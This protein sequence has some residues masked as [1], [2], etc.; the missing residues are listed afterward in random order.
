MAIEFQTLDTTGQV[1]PERQRLLQKL[2]LAVDPADAVSKK[3]FGMNWKMT[4]KTI[5]VQLHHKVETLEHI[6]KHFALVIQ[7]YLIDYLKQQFNFAHLNTGL[8]G[9]SFHIHVYRLA[10]KSGQFQ[11]SLRQRLSTDAAGVAASLSLQSSA[12][13]EL[14]MIVDKLE[15]KMSASTL[16]TL[17]API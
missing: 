6:G 10:E 14:S 11:L 5:L 8:V 17:D 16:L 4:A 12:K 7:D 3:R 13:I 9:D 2:G 1:W 15:Q